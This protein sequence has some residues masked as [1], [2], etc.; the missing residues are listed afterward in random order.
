MAQFGR[1]MWGVDV[2]V[3]APPG[4]GK[5]VFVG[6]MARRGLIV[7]DTD[8]GECGSLMVTNRHALLGLFPAVVAVLPSEDVF[9][10]RCMSRGLAVGSDWYA[11]VCDALQD[12]FVVGTE[13]F[14]ADVLSPVPWHEWADAT[15]PMV[16]WVLDHIGLSSYTVGPRR[17]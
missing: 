12:H 7:Y 4:C 8:N 10:E 15:V 17:T 16:D 6:V 9:V 1:V 14:V 13:R 5:T 3:F 2:C 11:G